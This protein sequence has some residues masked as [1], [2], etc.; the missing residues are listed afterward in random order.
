MNKED[1]AGSSPQHP[2]EILLVDPN[3][4]EFPISTLPANI[5]RGEMNYISIDDDSLSLLHARIYY[6]DRV[7]EICI[8][9]LDSSNGIFVNQKPTSKNIL[10]ASSEIR[11]GMVTFIYHGYIDGDSPQA[12]TIQS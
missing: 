7:Q 3:G 11:L 2:G 1:Q 9:D 8:E 10:F 5:G 6:D 12:Q 4:M